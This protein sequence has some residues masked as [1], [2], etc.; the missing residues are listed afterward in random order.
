MIVNNHKTRI[1]YFI[2]GLT[3]GGKERRLIELLTYLK[4]K[5]GFEIMLVLTKEEIHYPAF[6]AL[7]IP[8][9]VIKK[10]WKRYDLT[11]FYKFYK[12]CRQFQPD[13]IHSWGRMQSLYSL[14]AVLAYRIPLI[15]S[16]ITT[17]PPAVYKKSA[18]S[19]L[20]KILFNFSTVILSN[21][22][23]GI[24]AFNPP[25]KKSYVIYN[26][27]NPK[28]FMNLP[29]AA[30]IKEKYKIGTPTAVVMAASFTDNK[31]YDTFFNVA[32]HITR[33]RDDITFIGVGRYDQ[34]NPKYERILRLS[35]NNPRIIFPGRINDVEALVNACDIGV[36][37]SQDIH[38]EG[39]S[40][41][42]LEYMALGKPV[43]A[44]DSGGTKEIVHHNKNGYLITNQTVEEI[45]DL[46]L[47][48]VIDTEKYR[49]FGAA[50]RNIIKETFALE[51]MGFSFE[52]VYRAGMPYKTRKVIPAPYP[53][54]YTN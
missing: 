23:A 10:S 26:G 1:L 41:S 53:H 16:Q 14:P 5:G 28:R 36:L 3:A 37:F 17:A 24:A 44:N 54:P 47:S 13:L 2:G 43:I 35:N 15:N 42:I 30:A 45:A 18:V 48:L 32:E 52:Q 46:I 6:H 34:D 51:T 27:M 25:A 12:I 22:K 50:S 31:D 11:I 7:G 4:A 49:A 40:N 19:L 21:S 20:D 38:G 39:L 8:Y 9:Q 33:L 29:P